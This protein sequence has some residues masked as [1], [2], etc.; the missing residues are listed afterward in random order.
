MPG[1]ICPT[2]TISLEFIL[3]ATSSTQLLSVRELLFPYECVP[4]QWYTHSS[5]DLD[6]YDEKHT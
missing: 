5:S 1:V 4:L 2:I 3:G 6:G